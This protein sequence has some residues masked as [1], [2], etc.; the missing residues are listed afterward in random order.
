MKIKNIELYKLEK[1]D[2][3]FL[4]IIVIAVLGVVL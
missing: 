4:T 1:V 2:Y 3:I